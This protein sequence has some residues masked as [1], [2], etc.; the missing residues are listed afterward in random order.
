MA[1]ERAT[2]DI[3]REHLKKHGVSGQV[4]SEQTSSDAQVKRALAAAS[5]GGSGAGKPEFI[6]RLPGHPKLVIVVECKPDVSRHESATRDRPV[7]F[8][9]DGAVHYSRHLSKV[10]DVISIAVSGTDPAA[11]KIST[12]RQLKSQAEPEPLPGDYGPVTQLLPVADYPRLLT[13]DPAVRARS[14][15]DLLA[16]SRILH[17]YM[18]DYAKLSEQEKP[19]VVSGILLALK[20][21]VFKTS[22]E[23]YKPRDL[24]R[25]LY[26]AIQREAEVAEFSNKKIS[27]MLQPY[28]FIVTHPELNKLTP[29]S[30]DTPLRTLVANIDQ[31]LR[32]FLDNYHDID[33]IG[34]FYGEFLRYTGGDQ[35]GLGIVLTP[36]HLTELFTRIANVSPRDTVLDTC[37]GTGGFLIAAMAEMDSKVGNDEEAR[38][39]IRERQLIGVEQQPHMFA[40]AVSNMILRGDG[41]ANIYQGSCFQPDITN[42]LQ[43]G[44]VDRHGRPTVGLI[45][46]PFSQRGEGLHEL[47]LPRFDGQ[48]ATR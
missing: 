5:K 41:K 46:P 6:V 15:S 24:A 31:H 27:V 25:E 26:R 35:Q 42:N 44:V 33:V 2:E 8:A 32:P 43:Q 34:Q 21:D 29:E 16:F 28:S 10:F 36:R 1:N 18:R 13:L 17:N 4:V 37:C 9:V 23:S 30:V 40:L 19:F 39:R 12:F 3:V 48:G 38:R 47:E 22:W 7:E 14:H 20:D 45:N 11:L